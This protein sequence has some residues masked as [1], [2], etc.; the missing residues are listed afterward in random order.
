MGLP[1]RFLEIS[2]K[3]D[4]KRSEANEKRAAQIVR[5]GE[6]RKRMA[7]RTN[8]D[9]AE[10]LVERCATTD[11]PESATHVQQ[12]FG[13][14]GHRPGLLFEPTKRRRWDLSICHQVFYVDSAFSQCG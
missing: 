10:R 8:G 7:E 12:G 1:A 4:L 5:I 13:V 2:R 14:R 6:R 9:A 3:K 11:R